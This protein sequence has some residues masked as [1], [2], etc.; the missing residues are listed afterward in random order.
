MP[1]CSDGLSECKI[2]QFENSSAS[3]GLSSGAGK[4]GKN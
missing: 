4:N 2:I 1:V 3:A